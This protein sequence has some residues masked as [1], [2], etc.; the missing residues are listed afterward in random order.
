MDREIVDNYYSEQHGYSDPVF[1]KNSMRTFIS[2]NSALSKRHLWM[3][4]DQ[5]EYQLKC[6]INALRQLLYGVNECI[7]ATAVY[8][9]RKV[10]DLYASKR[11]KKNKT[12]L[13]IY[14]TYTSLKEHRTLVSHNDVAKILN[15]N[16]KKVCSAIKDV[17]EFTKGAR[18]QEPGS[19][20]TAGI[21]VRRVIIDMCLPMEYVDPVSDMFFLLVSRAEF[22]SHKHNS[23]LAGVLCYYLVDKHKISEHLKTSVTT[24]CQ[25]SRKIHKLYDKK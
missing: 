8:V 22:A 17:H 9:Y 25:I 7:I 13:F 5:K 3:T 23:L 16:T 10:F 19:E 11:C 24:A 15:F 12:K 1:P 21:D 4:T 14:C 2:G 20:Q 18:I 6:D